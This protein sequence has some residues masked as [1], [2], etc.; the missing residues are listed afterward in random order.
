MEE[1]F[2]QLSADTPQTAMDTLLAKI[3]EKYFEMAAKVHANERGNSAVRCRDLEHIDLQ[4]RLDEEIHEH[5][6]TI[7]GNSIIVIFRNV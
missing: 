6:Q 3:Q 7:T 4:R 2:Q 1:L 5:K